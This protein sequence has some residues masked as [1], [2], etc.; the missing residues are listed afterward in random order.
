MMSGPGKQFN[1]IVSSGSWTWMIEDD[2]LLPLAEIAVIYVIPIDGSL[3]VIDLLH[4][5]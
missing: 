1:E 5:H 4:G 3:S 2:W